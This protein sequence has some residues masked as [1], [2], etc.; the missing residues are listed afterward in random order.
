MRNSNIVHLFCVFGRD[1]V[2][3]F[4]FGA[5]CDLWTRNSNIICKTGQASIIN[6][7][8]VSLPNLV[9]EGWGGWDFQIFTFQTICI[10]N[11][12]STRLVYFWRVKFIF[13]RISG[14]HEGYYSLPDLGGG[15]GGGCILQ[16]FFFLVQNVILFIFCMFVFDIR[17]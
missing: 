7:A 14:G 1:R 12:I 16:I 15:V 13:S 4:R 8:P 3:V 10:L 17:G 6:S 2:G 9:R 5:G 11:S